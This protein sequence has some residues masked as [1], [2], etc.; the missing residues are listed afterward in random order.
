MVNLIKI[1]I[2]SFFVFL[3]FWSFGFTKELSIISV[4]FCSLAFG[5]VLNMFWSLNREIQ[6]KIK[7]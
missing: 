6:M 3:M 4:I 1:G 7:K 5:Y 2:C